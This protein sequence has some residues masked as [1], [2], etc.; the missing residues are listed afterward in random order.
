MVKVV[1]TRDPKRI[2]TIPS[3]TS[4]LSLYDGLTGYRVTNQRQYNRPETSR[5]RVR[6]KRIYEYVVRKPISTRMCRQPFVG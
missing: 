6:E 3:A 4:I 1:R 5:D 2:A